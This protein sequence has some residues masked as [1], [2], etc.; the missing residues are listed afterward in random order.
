LTAAAALVLAAGVVTALD[1][2]DA[3]VRPT[4][5]PQRLGLPGVT[6]SVALVEDA[7]LVT[8]LTVVVAVDLGATGRGD[9]GGAVAPES[10][11]LLGLS[12]RGFALQPVGATLPLRLQDVGRFGSGL[13]VVV[14]V[15]VEVVVADCSVNI[16]APRRIEL[17][18]R[19]GNGPVRTVAVASR[20]AVVRAL[21]GL[22]S[23]TC[24]RPR[25]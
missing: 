21:D 12:G 4:V 24:R 25:G 9:T 15:P 19:R 10:L 7:P 2:P 14:P 18:L 1:Q 13:P 22:V 16:L 20:P 6:A 23:R 8:R 5:L 17:S 11:Q 3:P